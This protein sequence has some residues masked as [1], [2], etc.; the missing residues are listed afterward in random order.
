MYTNTRIK[1]G[2]L[3]M[4]SDYRIRAQRFMNLFFPYLRKYPNRIDLAVLFFNR[5]KKMFVKCN[6]GLVRRCLI[7]SDY[8]IKWDYNSRG[9][10]MYGGCK[11]EYITFQEA[12]EDGYDYLLA[13]I[14]PFEV[15]GHIFYVMPRIDTLA[16]DFPEYLSD[17]ISDHI[18]DDEYDYLFYHLHLSD[19]HNENWGV[20]NHSPVVI[21]YACRR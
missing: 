20:L 11:D 8:V 10:K 1:K 6:G 12:K 17:D 16:E 2:E 18:S 9:R 21:D 5:D 3:K 7:L 13:E 15:R 4:K 19:I 14:T